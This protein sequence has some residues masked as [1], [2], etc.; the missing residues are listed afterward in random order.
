MI[1]YFFTPKYNKSKYSTTK[2]KFLL[3]CIH[4]PECHIRNITNFLQSTSPGAKTLTDY[5][6]MKR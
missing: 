3:S 2:K 4:I 6:D 1:L 5:Y